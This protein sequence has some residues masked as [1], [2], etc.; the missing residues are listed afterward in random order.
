MRLA[1][2]NQEEREDVMMWVSDLYKDVYGSRPRG[3]NF[4]AFSNAELATFVNDLIEEREHEAQ[5]EAAFVEKAIEDVMSLGA[6][7]ETA[8]RWLDQADA[9]FMY[10]DD[11]FYE[12]S[13]E[14]Y[15]WVAS[16]FE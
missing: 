7:R 6:D 5:M 9:F 1:I 8:L 2:T 12:D 3:Y 11:S 13:I 10:G 4:E 15:G 16:Q 14:K